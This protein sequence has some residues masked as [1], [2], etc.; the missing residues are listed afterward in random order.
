MAWMKTYT[1]RGEK[2]LLARICTAHQPS[3][4][5]LRMIFKLEDVSCFARRVGSL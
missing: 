2:L 1:G 3:I 5:A 4:G